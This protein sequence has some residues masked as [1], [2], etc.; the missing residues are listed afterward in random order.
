MLKMQ[1]IET[2]GT[3]DKNGNLTLDKP[4]DLR[5]MPVKV[6]VSFEKKI[7]YDDSEMSEK[8]WLKFAARSTAFDILSNPAEDIYTLEDGKPI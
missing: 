3:V 1:H 6:V 7:E 2:T 5:D 4:L 8:E